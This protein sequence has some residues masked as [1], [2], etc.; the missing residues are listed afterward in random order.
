MSQ[1]SRRLTIQEFICFLLEQDFFTHPN[2]C[3]VTGAVNRRPVTP[4][5]RA[6]RKLDLGALDR[7]GVWGRDGGETKASPYHRG[8][9][10][11]GKGDYAFITHMI[12]T[13]RAGSGRVGAVVPHG[14]LFRGAAEGRIR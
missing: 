2:L 7:A 13:A 5:G 1:R 6:D 10:P 14:V 11:K 8:V 3:P 12:E 4:H 9:P